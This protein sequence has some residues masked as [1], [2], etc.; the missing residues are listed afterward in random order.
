MG[1]FLSPDP[2]GL[3]YADPT[4]PQS[5]NLYSYAQNNP[6]TNIDPT[7]LD[8]VYFNDD[9]S[10]V[11][12]PDGIDHNSNSGEC[13]TNGG[14][15]VNGTTSAD[16]IQYHSDS[17]NFTINSSDANGNYTTIASAPGSQV[18][19][20]PCYGNCAQAYIPSSD[21]DTL[22]PSA[23]AILSQVGQQTGFILKAGN[24][25]P[26]AAA[27]GI[28]S[29][30]GLPGNPNISPGTMLR[31]ARSTA[32]NALSMGAA[33]QAGFAV[34]QAAKV[35]GPAVAQAAGE[36][37]ANTVAKAA[38]PFIAA[39]QGLYAAGRAQSNF[40]GCYAHE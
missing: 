25:L 24:C 29:Y 26:G 8:C 32:K 4:N 9:G 39:A 16:Q 21:T 17:D 40:S 14:D 10:G 28:A 34:G 15:W 20:I 31:A 36:L 18:G 1:R 5:F 2:S 22:N 12:G 3:E 38:V 30:V 7:G 6:L 37:V 13:G 27:T 23:Q 11:D 35:L 19:G 33:E